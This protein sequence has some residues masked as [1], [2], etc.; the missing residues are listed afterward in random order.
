MAVATWAEVTGESADDWRGLSTVGEVCDQLRRVRPKL[1][2]LLEGVQSARACDR[3]PAEAWLRNVAIPSAFLEGVSAAPGNPRLVLWQ[4]AEVHG[5]LVSVPI[6]EDSP[7]RPRTQ[8]GMSKAAAH[9]SAVFYRRSRGTDV[10]QVTTL[11]QVG[12]GQGLDFI[13][14][15]ICSRIALAEA[16]GQD[17]CQIDLDDPDVER[18]FTDVKDVA[19]AFAIAGLSGT[20]GR[21]YICSTGAAIAI[22][23]LVLCA[24][25]FSQVKVEIIG[26]RQGRTGA[27]PI[28]FGDSSSLRRLGW[29]PTTPIEDS[30]RATLE[31]ERHRAE[32]AP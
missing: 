17:L 19:R 31:F 2:Y 3:E 21:S 32:S 5:P 29:A 22:R 7:L 27:A 30:V 20:T 18:D 6:R 23:D 16:R 24:E 25:S 15:S 1:V 12:P 8:Y 9:A 14:P 13:V 10:I 26:R 11:N 4:S 28:L